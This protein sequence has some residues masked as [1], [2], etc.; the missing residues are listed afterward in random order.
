MAF[1]EYYT[2]GPNGQLQLIAVK[3]K[4]MA[5]EKKLEK[6]LSTEETQLRDVAKVSSSSEIAVKTATILAVLAELDELRTKA[7]VVVV[8]RLTEDIEREKE[9]EKKE[10]EE[11]EAEKKVAEEKKES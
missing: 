5:T 6:V 8:V 10:K 7:G 1:D 9:K 3:D 2:R 11:K 4:Q